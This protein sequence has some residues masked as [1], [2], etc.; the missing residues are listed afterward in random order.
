MVGEP[1]HRDPAEVGAHHRL[2]AREGVGA[3]IAERGAARADGQM[4]TA[5]EVLVRVDQT[6]TQRAE[7][8]QAQRSAEGRAAVVE[9]V[10]AGVGG[11]IAGAQGA[12]VGHGAD[13]ESV[14]DDDDGL[15]HGCLLL[16]GRPY[17]AR[18]WASYSPLNRGVPEASPETTAT[19]ERV[20]KICVRKASSA[21]SPS[22]TSWRSA[23]ASS[24]R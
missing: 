7:H 10:S 9:D 19:V 20:T 6:E 15:G 24:S 8:G 11:E 17:R 12:R 16:R 18:P 21:V 22:R 23:G 5:G 2:V 13:A 4:G 14:D 3:G 1:G